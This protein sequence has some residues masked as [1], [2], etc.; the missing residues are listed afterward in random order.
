MG[1]N[2]YEDSEYIH[3]YSENTRIEIDEPSYIYNVNWNIKYLNDF[4]LEI[5]YDIS[6]DFDLEKAFLEF[7]YDYYKEEL[8]DIEDMVIVL[9][10][11]SRKITVFIERLNF[12]LIDEKEVED[13]NFEG[14]IIEKK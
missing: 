4:D 3:F 5:Y 12:R 9:D 8:Q 14:I 7:S 10:N 11:G 2:R 13:L 6:K 1:Y